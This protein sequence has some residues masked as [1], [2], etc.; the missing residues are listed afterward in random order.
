M[1]RGA[2]NYDGA[3]F[4]HTHCRI[5]RPMNDAMKQTTRDRRGSSHIGK[6]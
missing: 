3:R 1:L 5:H 2:Y 4:H 6:D